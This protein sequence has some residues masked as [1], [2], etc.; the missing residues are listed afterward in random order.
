M[1]TARSEAFARCVQSRRDPA[2]GIHGRI[3]AVL[4]EAAGL[5][6][7]RRAPAGAGPHARAAP[8]AQ[9]LPDSGLRFLVKNI[10]AAKQQQLGVS[11]SSSRDCHWLAEKHEPEVVEVGELATI[12]L[13]L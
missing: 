6:P 5:L 1:T 7:P 2:L 4:P 10:P 9:A 13:Y 8:C 3:F 12:A 11:R